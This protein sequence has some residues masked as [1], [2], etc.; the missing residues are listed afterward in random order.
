MFFNNCGVNDPAK[1]KLLLSCRYFL[2][3]EQK[4]YALELKIGGCFGIKNVFIIS[5]RDF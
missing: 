2:V 3:K 5:L 4:N 1:R